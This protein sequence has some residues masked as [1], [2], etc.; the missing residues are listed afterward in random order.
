VKKHQPPIAFRLR[1]LAVG[2][3]P[4]L[5]AVGLFAIYFTQRSGN[6]MLQILERQGHASAKHLAQASALDLISGNL[7][8]IKRLLDYEIN[9]NRFET[10]AITDSSNWLLISGQ[11]KLLPQLTG[12]ALPTSWQEGPILFFAHSI[13]PPSTHAFEPTLVAQPS[14]S[15]KHYVVVSL[16]RAPIELS[17]SRAGLAAFGTALI[18]TLFALLLAWRLSGHLSRPLHNI[19][20]TVAH[21]ASGELSERTPETSRGEIGQLESG[22]NRMAKAL[23]ENQ[24]NLTLRVREA[25]SELLA[26]KLAAEAAVLAKS[27]FLAAASHDMRQPL[28]ALT[29]L[30]AALREQVPDGEAA[31]LAKHIESSAAAMESLLNGL[32]DLS[33]LDAG[34]IEARPHCF[35]VQHIFN[36][37][38]E[39]FLPVAQA[40]GLRLHFVATSLCCYSDAVLV[41]RIVSNLV[42]NALRYTEQG[43]VLVGVRR[44]GPDWLRFEVRDTGKGIPHEFQTL[45][46]E[47]Y[48]QLENT[49]R[50]RD[51]GLGL[52]LAI[53]TRLTRLLGSQIQVNST[54]GRGAAFSFQLARCEAAEMSSESTSQSHSFALP[55]ENALVAIIDDD[56]AI[57]AAMVEIFDRW[58]VALAVGADA[59]QVCAELKTLGRAPDLILCDYRLTQGLTGIEAIQLLRDNFGADI[60]AALITGDTGSETMQ[61]IQTNDLPVLHKPLKPAKLR[62][63]LSHLL[64]ESS[65]SLLSTHRSDS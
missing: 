29:L 65:A 60:P 31:R 4:L 17:R 1:I 9:V 5:L 64:S 43:R 58:N 6:E 32:L 41:E 52:G 34:V 59:K 48:F 37:L 42:S 14:A 13:T 38:A 45:I 7:A 39:Q 54:P 46:F 33:K 8:Q 16:S 53:V 63:F 12:K 18:S 2:L 27:R 40:Q 24:N 47:E 3:I 61:S 26:Q 49:E 50:H 30:V 35:R 62:A 10:A 51:K 22:I 57:L 25:T 23:E 55:L 11:P 15:P 36:R 21:L 44:V 56:E 19:I 20:S 28:H